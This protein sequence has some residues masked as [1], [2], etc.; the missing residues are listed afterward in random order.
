MS[1]KLDPENIRPFVL[2]PVP[3]NAQGSVLARCGE[4]HVI[5]TAHVTNQIPS[6]LKEKQPPSGWVTA[7]YAMMPG[8]TLDR[9]KRGTDGRSSEI[10]RLIARVLRGAVDLQAMPGLMIHC[11]CEVLKADG[12][13]RTTAIN[14]AYV[15]LM[16]ALKHAQRQGW[17]GEV[18]LVSKEAVG[19]ISVGIID[20]SVYLDLDYELDKNA[21]VDLNVAMT[22][23]NRFIEIQGTGEAGSFGRDELNRMLDLAEKGIREIFQIQRA[24]L[25]QDSRHAS[26]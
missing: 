17:I 20:G 8:S 3:S 25:S 1:S 12:G 21:E 4:T 10:Q 18:S 16:Q 9:K 19:A 24:F 22:S 6:W 11:D 26:S 15:A 13:T 5:C 7:E 2:E 23:E 14:G